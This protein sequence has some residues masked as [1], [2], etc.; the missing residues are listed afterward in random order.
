MMFIASMLLRHW[1]RRAW[2]RIPLAERV[3][4]TTVLF[5][6]VVVTLCLAF[7]TAA[8]LQAML[9]PR[10]AAPPT[11]LPLAVDHA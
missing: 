6:G 3:H 9:P 1:T 4:T 11:P 8:I 10:A 5:W 2:A 7:L